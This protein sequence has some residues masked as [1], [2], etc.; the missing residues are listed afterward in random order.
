METTNQQVNDKLDYMYNQYGIEYSDYQ[1]SDEQN[2]D[3]LMQ[4]IQNREIEIVNLLL[5]DDNITIKPYARGLYDSFIIENRRSRQIYYSCVAID[6]NT[7]ADVRCFMNS[8]GYIQQGVK[9]YNNFIG[10]LLKI[11]SI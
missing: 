10:L 9:T 4:T 7:R 6:Q 2:N 8:T 1:F 11:K 5:D 3:E